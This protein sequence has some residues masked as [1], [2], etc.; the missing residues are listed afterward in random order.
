MDYNKFNID[1]KY[2]S[3]KNITIESAEKILLKLGDSVNCDKGYDYYI[4][5]GKM[6]L[7]THKINEAIISLE[8]AVGFKNTDEVYDLLSFAY[9]NI[10]DYE[11]SL[12]Y[13][14]LSFGLNVDEYIYNHK[15]KIL[16][17]LGRL[18][19]CFETYYKGLKYALNTYSSY[20]EVEIFGENV[21][22][23]SGILKSTYSTEIKEFINS[24][25]YYNLY[26]SY[27]KLFELIS[28]EE[29]NDHYHFSTEYV[30]INY[31]ELLDAGK[32]VL[33]DNN[34]FIQMVNIY[35][36][37]YKIENNCE[38]EDKGY[39]NKIYIDNKVQ[40]LVNQVVDRTS[41]SND[42]DVILEVLDEVIKLKNK[43][44]YGYLYHKGFIYMKL[45]RYDEGINILNRTIEKDDCDYDI[46]VK[47]YECLI[48]TLHDVENKYKDSYTYYKEKLSDFLKYE[49]ECVI[50]NEFLTLD[51]QC[52]QL[53]HNCKR[54]IN[55]SLDDEF[56]Y[57]QLEGL[58]LE[59]GQ[60]YENILKNQSIYM[61]IENYNKAINIY[62]SLIAVKKNCAHG[63]YRK[64]RAIVLILRLLNSSKTSLKDISGVHRLDC[65]AYSEVIYNLNKAIS[66][67]N[68]NGKYFN[69][70]ARTH[71]E[72]GEYDQA[73][74][75]MEHAIELAPNDL[76]MNLNMVC[77]YIRKYQYT[78]AVDY[79]FKMSYKDM[80]RGT[81]RKTFLSRK[82]ILSF[83]MGI[84]NLY[85]RQDKIHCIIAYYFYGIVEFQY[86]KAIT[87][88]DNAIEM[89]DDER[90][91]LLRAKI[92][93]KNNKYEE[94]LKSVEEAIVIDDHY[95]EAFALREKCN[96]I[97]GCNN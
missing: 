50:K 73:L 92:Y 69:L 53:L 25:D 55:L 43:D 27:M 17:K 3:Y 80:D 78:E 86:N 46:K 44:Y 90:Y 21:A 63:Y 88:I 33:I 20:G 37:L 2:D 1:E 68:D 36:S 71:F 79:L 61:I 14:E 97:L 18:E 74:S 31:L 93:F 84:F 81:V 47:S 19:L 65:F 70:L 64:G 75:Y 85:Q 28:K 35:K 34:C 40:E 11:K 41:L 6:L 91:Y 24:G 10:E 26:K 23:I 54:A 48:K 72:I 95:D 94:A 8:K 15:G 87:F 96:E 60:K 22:R 16:E 12:K 42:V 4:L 7:K 82:E 56:W 51:D 39:I 59:I 49:T 52:G 5:K 38:Y 67:K 57:E 45:N 83:L 9:Y 62:D 77:V 89:A 58:S 76:Y 32:Y 30:D 29:E 66:L 13:I